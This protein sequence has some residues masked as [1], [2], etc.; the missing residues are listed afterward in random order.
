MNVMNERNPFIVNVHGWENKGLPVEISGVIQFDLKGG[1]FSSMR[2][3]GDI[4]GYSRVSINKVNEDRVFTQTKVTILSTQDP[5]P[6]PDPTNNLVEIPFSIPI[7]PVTTSP[8][9]TLTTTKLPTPPDNRSKYPIT[10]KSSIGSINYRLRILFQCGS[11]TSSPMIETIVPII[12]TATNSSKSKQ[13]T[14]IAS[15]N[16]PKLPYSPIYS[17]SSSPTSSTNSS[18]IE[19]DAELYSKSLQQE[20]EDNIISRPKALSNLSP[21]EMNKLNTEV[22]YR[23]HLEVERMTMLLRMEEQRREEVWLNNEILK[24]IE[25]ASR[26]NTTGQD[27]GLQDY[28]PS[29]R[30]ASFIDD[31]YLMDLGLGGVGRSNS[32]GGVSRNQNQLRPQQLQQRDTGF[33]DDEANGRRQDVDLTKNV[34]AYVLENM[35]SRDPPP[36]MPSNNFLRRSLSINTN[37]SSIGINNS[38]NQ[39]SRSN[40]ISRD[41]SRSNGTTSRSPLMDLSFFSGGQRRRSAESRREVSSTTNQP[42]SPQSTTPKFHLIFPRTIATPRSRIPIEIHIAAIPSNRIIDHIELSLIAC[43]TARINGQEKQDRMVLAKETVFASEENL[44]G[45]KMEKVVLV[46]PGEDVMGCFGVGFWTEGLEVSH[47]VHAK[48]ILRKVGGGRGGA[49]SGQGVEEFSLGRVST[50]LTS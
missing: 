15:S 6:E 46:V 34:P 11:T 33:W 48:L 18:P 1:K 42:Q 26:L 24:S 41:R 20:V 19:T 3:V 28:V 9:T 5:I 40:T 35:E 49:G 50:I 43:V 17:Y 31:D 47:Y 44:L 32:T 30:P 10:F 12:I 22:L 2:I 14:P 16:S 45:I 38:T 21:D 36:P 29:A 23:R 7:L 25:A 8:P 39:V 27:G 37:T 4:T 13:Q